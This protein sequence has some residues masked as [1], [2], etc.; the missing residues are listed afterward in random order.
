MQAAL[1]VEAACDPAPA[2]S[3]RQHACGRCLGSGV[4]R[5]TASPAATV[6][7]ER[8]ELAFGLRIAFD[9]A[10]RH[11]EA[12]MAGEFLHIPETPPNLRDAARRAGNEGAASR[13]RRT[14]IHLQRGIE[15]MEPQ[16]HG[17]W[18][19]PPAPLREQERPLGGG[20]VRARRLQ[21]HERGLEVGVEGNGAAPRLAF[22]GAVGYVEHLESREMLGVTSKL[23]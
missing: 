20:H 23:G 6:L 10:L 2:S 19:Q 17:R 5:H 4:L 1:L 13:V 11:G 18:R 12:G 9:V 8:D 22:T 7:Q 21:R 14:P 15:A 16:A 3:A